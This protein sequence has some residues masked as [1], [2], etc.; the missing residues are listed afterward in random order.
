[1]ILELKV[2]IILKLNKREVNMNKPK[3]FVEI[4]FK[5]IPKYLD[6]GYVIVAEGMI[7]R[8]FYYKDHNCLVTYKDNQIS[9]ITNNFNIEY[10]SNFDYGVFEREEFEN[11]L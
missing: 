4:E 3:T 11:I 2:V 8:F 5:D 6:K 1:M 9:S 10:N 7:T